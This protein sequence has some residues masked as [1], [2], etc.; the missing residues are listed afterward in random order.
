MAET[1]LRGYLINVKDYQ[2]FDNI[3]TFFSNDNK[4]YNLLSLGSRKIL[5]KNGR[6]MKFG[7][8]IEFEFFKARNDFSLSR[9]KK[10]NLI[11]DSNWSMES[12]DVI[13]YLNNFLVRNNNNFTFKEYQKIIELFNKKVDEKFIWLFTLFKMIKS[14]GVKFHLLS[15]VICGYKRIKTTSIGFYGFLCNDCAIENNEYIYS[16][17]VNEIFYLLEKKQY[18]KIVFFDSYDKEIAIKFL[19]GYLNINY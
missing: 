13:V 10:M 3:L 12:N 5:S 8:E 4:V 9:L 11:E 15:C 16:D 6:N 1:I 18:K 7:A 14:T 17:K 2:M 19:Q